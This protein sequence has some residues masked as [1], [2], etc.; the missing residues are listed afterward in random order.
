MN[1]IFSTIMGTFMLI[2]TAENLP[3]NCVGTF[4]IEVMN[5][6]MVDAYEKSRNVC[7]VTG[8]NPGDTFN[9]WIGFQIIRVTDLQGRTRKLGVGGQIEPPKSDDID[10]SY[11]L[12]IS[13]LDRTVNDP[14]GS[15]THA[16]QL[17]S[18]KLRSNALRIKPHLSVG[19]ADNVDPIIN[20]QFEISHPKE[21][22]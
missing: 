19:D 8:P 9:T 6:Q 21:T 11:S 5:V 16:V 1:L 20:V 22:D 3:S 12:N 2:A 15:F 4:K 17:A 7:L 10:W 14:S 13:D 18:S